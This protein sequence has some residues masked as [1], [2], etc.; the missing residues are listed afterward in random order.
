VSFPNGSLSS[1]SPESQKHHGNINAGKYFEVGLQLGCVNGQRAH[2]F[3]LGFLLQQQYGTRRVS[4]KLRVTP[5]RTQPCLL[6]VCALQF[7]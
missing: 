3:L 5:C 6:I 1:K 4:A 7:F 2:P